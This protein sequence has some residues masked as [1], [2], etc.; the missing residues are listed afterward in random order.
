MSE[1]LTYLHLEDGAESAR[2]VKL[3]L[4]SP[5]VCQQNLTGKYYPDPRRACRDLLL[6]SQYVG[7]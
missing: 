3:R 7:L 5:K 4:I 1:L 2:L 6:K